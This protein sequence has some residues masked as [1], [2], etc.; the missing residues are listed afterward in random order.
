MSWRHV[1]GTVG[2]S[3]LQVKSSALLLFFRE[4]GGRRCIKRVVGNCSLQLMDDKSMGLLAGLPT[5]KSP[6]QAEEGAHCRSKKLIEQKSGKSELFLAAAAV[7]VR[8]ESVVGGLAY[9]AA[10]PVHKLA[11]IHRAARICQSCKVQTVRE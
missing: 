4:V 9:V 10:G 7:S 6:F 1:L 2:H 3:N 5:G 11:I 8:E